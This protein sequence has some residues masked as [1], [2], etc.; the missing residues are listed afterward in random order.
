MPVYQ[1][2][3]PIARLCAFAGWEA[4]ASPAAAGL[5]ADAVVFVREDL[6]VRNGCFDEDE[7]LFTPHGEEWRAFCRDE[8]AFAVPDWE[9]ESDQVRAQLAAEA[10]LGVE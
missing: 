2:A 10:L 6:S 1:K 5:D 9:A 8:L 3:Y 7:V 4:A